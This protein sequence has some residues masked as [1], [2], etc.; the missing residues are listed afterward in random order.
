MRV[1]RPQRAEKS[2]IVVDHDDDPRRGL[3]LVL[4]SLE[5][6]FQQGAAFFVAGADDYRHV[7]GGYRR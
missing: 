1:I 2:R 7:V 4:E 6:A 5:R 3:L